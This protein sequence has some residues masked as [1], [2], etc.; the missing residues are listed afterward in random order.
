MLWKH[1]N[2][3]NTIE[4]TQ[5]LA[6]SENKHFL[7]CEKFEAEGNRASF[8]FGVGRQVYNSPWKHPSSR[9]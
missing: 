7:P 9:V 3:E 6:A 8:I 5:K 2:M 1:G 4:M